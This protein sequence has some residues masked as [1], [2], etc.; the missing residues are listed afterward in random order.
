M[1]T[2][3]A[4]Q[5]SKEQRIIQ[6]INLHLQGNIS[7]AANYYQLFID[8]GWK[9]HRVFSNYGV[10]LKGLGKLQNAELLTRKAIQ[11]NPYWS[12]TFPN[13][14]NFLRDLGKS[15]EAKLEHQI[16]E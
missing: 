16:N 15:Q 11:L 5:T 1:S 8:E 4:S 9:D 13:L 6:A 2:K 3:I 14:G 12:D 7:E 10:I